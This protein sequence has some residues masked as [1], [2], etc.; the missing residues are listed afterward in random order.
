MNEQDCLF[1]KIVS[2]EIPA[3]IVFEDEKCIGILDIFPIS[4]GHTLI[5]PKNHYFTMEDIPNDILTHLMVVVKMLGKKIHNQMNIDGYN[6]LQNNFP[7]AGQVINHFHI[8]IIPRL[9][10]DNKFQIKIPKLQ[11]DE[12]KLEEVKSE[13]LS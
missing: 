3:K 9:M 13:I 7:A 8:H 2:N 4:K 6:I 5:I 10:N 11:I 12:N 1:C